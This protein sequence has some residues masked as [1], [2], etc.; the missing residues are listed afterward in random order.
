MENQ[1]KDILDHYVNNLYSLVVF[2]WLESNRYSLLLFRV[3]RELLSQNKEKFICFLSNIY[4]ENML[5]VDY[6]EDYFL[7]N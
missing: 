7:N 1:E 6:M 2:E 4:K 3:K 5:N